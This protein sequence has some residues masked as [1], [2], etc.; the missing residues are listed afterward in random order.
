[1]GNY[2]CVEFILIKMI[3]FIYGELRSSIG[4]G[5]KITEQKESS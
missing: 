4:I 3:L 1:M 2:S 5:D